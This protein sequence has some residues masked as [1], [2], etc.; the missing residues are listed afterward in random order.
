[1]TGMKYDVV[2]VG[3]G[4]GG[5]VAS[6]LL[7][8]SG[9][10]TAL[11]EKLEIFGGRYTT[12]DYKGYLITSAAVYLDNPNGPTVQTLRDIGAEN[13]VQLIKPTPYLKY[14]FNGKD[15][16][17]P[18]KGGAAAIIE[19]V[20]R[21]KWEKDRVL[22][23]LYKALREEKE[24]PSDEISFAQWL[25]QY[26]DNISIHKAWDTYAQTILGMW[27][28]EIPAGA[29]I[30]SV[31]AFRKYGSYYMW[32]K[33]HLR[34]IITAMKKRVDKNGVSMNRCKVKQIKVNNGKVEGVLAEREGREI[35][36]DAKIV[37]CNA[38]PK[39]TVEMA[40][41]KNFTAEY[42]RDLR[43]SDHPTN[44]ANIFFEC[45]EPI[46]DFPGVLNVM[47]TDRPCSIYTP[48]MTW[49]D[50]APEGKHCLWLWQPFPMLFKDVESE[51]E[52]GIN[53]CRM[54][55]PN[56]DKRAKVLLTSWFFGDW[57]L[58][59][60]A[61]GYHL[62]QTTPIENLYNVGDGCSANDVILGEGSSE[63]ARVVV[64]MVKKKGKP[65]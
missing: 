39:H 43:R 52:K 45:D 27:I 22:N 36:I 64:D 14:R 48:S 58:N 17:I 38:G 62:Y 30:R 32:P 31:R 59:R 6:S 2:V 24:T 33:G 5:M 29:F 35:D 23:A 41:A 19:M 13:E 28:R 15:Y 60:S 16:E 53:N 57:P 51:I 50:Y 8:H 54:C 25:E 20:A 4:I 34:T 49:P 61:C 9:Y 26:T 18:E 37:I 1:M 7:A 11:L 46:M 44:G 65:A 55:F 21:D 3:S 10:K 56:F 12:I 40:G 42:M 63:S 47:D